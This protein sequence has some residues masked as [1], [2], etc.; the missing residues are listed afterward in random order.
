VQ[1]QAQEGYRLVYLENEGVI[2]VVAGFRLQE[3]LSRSRFLYVDDLVTDEEARS[4]G[5]GSALFAWLAR[6]AKVQ[7]CQRLELDS[8]VQRHAA[9]RFYFTQ[10]MHISSYHFSLDLRDQK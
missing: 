9:H 7:G 2:K 1:R 10:G 4:R 5:Y 3:M 6:Y 8:G